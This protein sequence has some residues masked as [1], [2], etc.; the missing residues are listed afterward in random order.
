MA[1]LYS[2]EGMTPKIHDDVYIAPGAKVIGNV[3]LQEGSNVW[4]N[5]VIRGD[6]NFVRI[7]KYADIQDNC[8][9]HVDESLVEG[10]PEQDAAVI[11]DHVTIGHSA[12]VHACTIEDG[13]LIGMGAV[14]LNGALIGKGSVIGAGAVVTQGMVIPPFSVALGSPAKVVKTLSEES[15][16]DRLFHADYYYQLS[17][18]HKQSA[19]P[20]SR[21]DCKA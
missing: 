3:E 1:E 19:V 8:V 10:K 7:G 2:Y 9:I 13:C 11:G 20:V 21:E 14:V 4:Y 16:K 17:L 6:N 12:V 15:F 18:K 5:A